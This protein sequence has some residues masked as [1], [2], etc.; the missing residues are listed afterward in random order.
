MNRSSN[1]SLVTLL[2]LSCGCSSLWHDETGIHGLLLKKTPVGSSYKDVFTYAQ[3]KGWH[4]TAG[5]PE[6]VFYYG[7]GTPT[8]WITCHLGDYEQSGGRK[9][10]PARV[11]VFAYW[12][13]D[14]SDRMLDV[15]V[16]KRQSPLVDELNPA[17]SGRG[18]ITSV[19][20]ADCPCRAV[21]E[22]Q[23]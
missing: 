14:E 8:K 6:G 22:Q 13:F 9:G 19:F 4:P 18:A 23:C 12:C 5:R 15:I 2:V 16:C 20:Q 10:I 17:A 11:D 21:P 3:R 7:S 1:I